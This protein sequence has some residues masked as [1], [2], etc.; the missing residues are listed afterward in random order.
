MGAGGKINCGQSCSAT[1][2][3]GYTVALTATADP[4]W[5]FNKWLG[6]CV[7]GYVKMSSDK[8]C[9]AIFVEDKITEKP[10]FTLTVTNQYKPDEVIITSNDGSL[11]CGSACSGFFEAGAIVEL[12]AKAL[13]PN[14]VFNSWKGDCAGLDKISFP[15]NLLINSNK[16]CK[17]IFDKY[18]NLAITQPEGGIIS[19]LLPGGDFVSCPSV[20]KEGSIVTL[21]AE[22]DGAYHFSNWTGDCTSDTLTMNKDMACSAIF[23]QKVNLSVGTNAGGMVTSYPQGINCGNGKTCSAQFT[24]SEKVVLS[25]KSDQGYR[26]NGWSGYDECNGGKEPNLRIIMNKTKSCNANFIKRYTININLLGGT[27]KIEGSGLICSG[28]FC[29]GTYDSGVTASLLAVPDNGFIFK[30]WSGDCGGIEKST[31]VKVDSDK[32][33]TATFTKTHTLTIGNNCT[34]RGAPESC[35]G[36]TAVKINI[37]SLPLLNCYINECIYKDV[38]QGKAVSVHYTM[39]QNTNYKFNGWSG[40]CSG[41]GTSQNLTMNSDKTCHAN[42]AR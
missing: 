18:Y 27:G 5:K 32:T 26:F 4:G 17:P 7:N 10:K 3:P 19:C 13:K 23:T 9:T 36:Y 38:E 11:N 33:C 37:P 28:N 29:T 41:T 16:S 1:F 14:M 25:A 12:M 34:Y 31:S 2:D 24:P 6:D 15:I 22:P 42:F 30:N 20:H 21:K 35:N 40:N 39:N 8:A